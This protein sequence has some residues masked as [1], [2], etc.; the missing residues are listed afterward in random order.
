MF[1]FNG[2]WMCNCSK[3][4]AN[5]YI[6]NN[7]A[8]WISDKQFRLNFVSGGFGHN[9]DSPY[10]AELLNNQCVVCGDCNNLTRHHV[11]P[12]MFIK[13]LPAKFK[14]NNQHDIV[15]M[16]NDCHMSYENHASLFKKQFALSYDLDMGKQNK[17]DILE[18]MN[19]K[20]LSARNAL[21]LY[22]L[23]KVKIPEEK[24]L[25]L[26]EVGNMEIFKFEVVD[27]DLWS[28]KLID[29]IL[30]NESGLHEFSVA[31]RK[32]FLFY[33]KPKHMPK[34]WSV[35]HKNSGI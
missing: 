28:K 26:I 14:N 25:F 23:N 24:L 34:H 12:Y 35:E 7:L 19:K 29:H 33:A 6:K 31:W 8:E 5:W 21:D 18:R 4:K 15:S 30:L 10:Y 9:K 22:F 27:K 16:C 1:H 20:I 13:H 11:V 3:K 2:D 32:H 17:L